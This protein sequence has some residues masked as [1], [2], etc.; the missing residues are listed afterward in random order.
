MQL[1]EDYKYIWSSGNSGFDIF[2][3]VCFGLVL[4]SIPTV[5]ITVTI[6]LSIATVALL[7]FSSHHLL[8][9]NNDSFKAG[10]LLG[11]IL[12]VGFGF[13]IFANYLL[14]LYCVTTLAWLFVQDWIVR[15]SYKLKHGYG[16]QLKDS[17]GIKNFSQ[18]IATICYVSMF[19]VSGYIAWKNFDMESYYHLKEVNF[20]FNEDFITR[21]SKNDYTQL[22]ASAQWFNGKKQALTA[23]Y[24]MMGNYGLA[25]SIITGIFTTIINFFSSDS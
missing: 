7:S 15:S 24:K 21:L 3:M 8:G 18:I 23:L 10:I 13:A 25:L 2:R 14:T 11:I 1:L 19:I 12:F 17:F 6:T 9:R 22:I 16:H 5:Y 20:N 4:L